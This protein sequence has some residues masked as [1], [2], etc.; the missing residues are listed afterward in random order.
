MFII[1][2]KAK[3]LTFKGGKMYGELGIPRSLKERHMS[4]KSRGKPLSEGLKCSEF[5][6]KLQ[7]FKNAVRSQRWEQGLEFPQ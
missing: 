3:M 6:R 1:I 5:K 7:A 4:T 2:G